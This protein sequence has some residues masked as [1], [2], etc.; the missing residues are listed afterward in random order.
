MSATAMP[1]FLWKGHQRRRGP[2]FMAPFYQGLGET[3]YV[4]E[5][6]VA[7]EYRVAQGH[8]DRFPALAADLV[9]RKVDLIVTGNGTPW[10][11]AAKNATSTIP[12]VFIGAPGPVA[13]AWS[14]VS[15]G[16]AATSQASRPSTAS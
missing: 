11:V 3:G 5:Q 2:S 1:H 14:P 4:E 15:P 9:G 6:N 12:I 10:A 7:I 8:Y 13:S 16:R